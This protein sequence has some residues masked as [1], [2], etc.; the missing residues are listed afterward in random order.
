MNAEA[1][2]PA[3]WTT[4]VINAIKSIDKNHL[5]IDGALLPLPQMLTQLTR[6]SC[7]GTNG[8]WNCT[9]SSRAMARPQ[10]I[11]FAL[12]DTTGATP[13]GLQVPT[14]DIVTDHGVR[15]ASL[16]SFS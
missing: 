16:L 8:L 1:W 3:A 5:V 11:T 4:A 6:V 12:P 7:A 15:L 9:L 14:V 13:A 10:L 2:P